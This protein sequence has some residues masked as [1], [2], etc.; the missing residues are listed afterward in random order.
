MTGLNE[1][2]NRRNITFMMTIKFFLCFRIVD[3]V[4]ETNFRGQLFQNGLD[5]AMY[6]K[7]IAINIQVCHQAI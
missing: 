1:L 2:D 6:C 5:E 7:L 4:T 3:D